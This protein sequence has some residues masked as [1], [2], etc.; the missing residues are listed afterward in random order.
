[1]TPPFLKW[2]GM[3]AAD[4]LAVRTAWR[5]TAEHGTHF[6]LLFASHETIPGAVTLPAWSTAARP[7]GSGSEMITVRFE[8]LVPIPAGANGLRAVA[9]LA[10]VGGSSPATTGQVLARAELSSGPIRRNLAGAVVPFPFGAQPFFMLQTTSPVPAA[11]LAKTQP[12]LLVDMP[13]RFDRLAANN[14]A[15]YPL[16]PVNG[17]SYSFAGPPAFNPAA[18]AA[19]AGTGTMYV[20]LTYMVEMNTT[21]ATDAVGV[22]GVRLVPDNTP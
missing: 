9:H 6:G 8:G 7:T 16:D 13:L 2:Q 18:Y 12:L 5:L 22:M 1:V 20:T 4:P 21:D 10:F 11:P 19:Q 14:F 15:G 17:A 3:A